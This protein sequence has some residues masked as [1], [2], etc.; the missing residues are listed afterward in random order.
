[1]NL[2]KLAVF[3]LDGT[4]LDERSSIS[5]ESAT[6]MRAARI[7]GLACT[8]ASGRDLER[9]EPFLRQLDWLEVP[10]ITEQGAVIVEPRNG[11]ILMERGISQEILIDTVEALRSTSIP[12][13]VILYGRSVPQVFRNA[14][15]PSY[16][17]GWA[18]GWYAAQLRDIPDAREVLTDGV[19][20]ISVKCLAENTDAIRR[21]LIETLGPRANV[22]KADV[23]F[24]NIM[25]AGV[26]KGSA[27]RWLIDYLGVHEADVMA[28]GD[29][30][31][32]WSMFTVAGVAVAVA[33]ADE[34]TRQMA[35][36]IVPSNDDQ[37][38]AVALESFTDGRFGI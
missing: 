22:V 7:A 15:A 36:Y 3:D 8:V 26:D 32:D 37:G 12:L 16:V 21:L 35:R 23:N 38:A 2:D 5:D 25:D 30:E 33:N 31:A 18:T 29:C 19:R 10:V 11:H 6:R 17:D 4:L 9:V 27:L 1:M 14:G 24:V 20:K 34:Q 13:N 28:V